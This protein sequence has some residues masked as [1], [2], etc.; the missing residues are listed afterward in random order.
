MKV[1]SSRFWRGRMAMRLSTRN[2]ER[3][4]LTSCPSESRE[5]T[6]QMWQTLMA[7]K[8]ASPT[9]ITA[10]D[11]ALYEL[12]ALAGYRRIRLVESA[13]RLPGVLWFV[14]LVGEWS[15]LRLPA[16]SALPMAHC[17]YPGECVCLAHLAGAG[18][19]CRYQSALPGL[20]PRERLRLPARASGYEEPSIAWLTAAERLR[21]RNALAMTETEL[22]LMAAAAIIGLSSNPN[23]G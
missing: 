18:G 15:P 1:Q 22:K 21:R 2:G 19:D 9:E 8:A 12:S 5:I 13:S 7:S 17:T 11:H 3:W 4:R 23:T 6:R 16:C 20:S 10:E 14:L